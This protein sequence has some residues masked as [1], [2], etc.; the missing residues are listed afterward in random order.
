MKGVVTK[1]NEDKGYGF[2]K[3]DDGTNLFFHISDLKT[4]KVPQKG[5]QLE[6][7]SETGEKGLVAKKI[8]IIDS[9]KKSG[10]IT[11]G[12]VRI[13]AKNIKTYGLAKCDQTISEKIPEKERDEM[14]NNLGDGAKFAIKAL[15]TVAAVAE[16]GVGGLLAIDLYLKLTH[17]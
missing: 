1:Y 16:Y 5:D 7:E 9:K 17:Q 4:S 6:F 14:R 8:H 12:S 2:I 15:Y 10:F 13:K 11:F 3:G